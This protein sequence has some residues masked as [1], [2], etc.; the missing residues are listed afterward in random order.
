METEDVTLDYCSKRQV[1]EQGS[2]GL[3]H[4]CVSVLSQALVIETVYLGDLL[5]FVVA[6]EDCDSVWVSDLEDDQESH[7]FDRVVATVHIVT[8]EEV[9]V[10]GQLTSNFEKFLQV[11]ELAVNISANGDWGSNRL[12]VALID[13]NLFG[14]LTESFDT[15]FWERLALTECF[16]LLVEVSD[17]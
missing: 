14:F 9:V 2:E 7:C 16:D 5:A 17:V 6:S 12:H 13:Q 4:V 1:V 11:V 8:H 3:P 15:V 10:V